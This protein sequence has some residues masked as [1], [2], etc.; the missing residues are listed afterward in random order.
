LI[1][2]YGEPAFRVAVRL[3]HE[4]I[5]GNGAEIPLQ[6][7]MTLTADIQQEHRTIGRCDDGHVSSYFFGV[8]R[9]SNSRKSAV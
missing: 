4:S 8:T 6:P 5:A 1:S 9:T 3:D 2:G 7:G